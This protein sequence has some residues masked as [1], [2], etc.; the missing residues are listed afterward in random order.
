M[1]ESVKS[2]KRDAIKAA[3]Q[4]KYSDYILARLNNATTESEICRLMI[5]GRHTKRYYYTHYNKEAFH[6]IYGS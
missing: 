3:R 5:E 2:Y 1:S 4:L 6:S